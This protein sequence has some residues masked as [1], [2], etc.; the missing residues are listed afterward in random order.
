[1]CT[2]LTVFKRWKQGFL[3]CVHI[4]SGIRSPLWEIPGPDVCRRCP[5]SGARSPPASTTW[6]YYHVFYGDCTIKLDR[7]NINF[8]LSKQLN[9][10]VQSPSR[11]L[12]PFGRVALGQDEDELAGLV[13]VGV[14]QPSPELG[15]HCEGQALGLLAAGGHKDDTLPVDWITTRLKLKEKHVLVLPYCL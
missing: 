3:Q 8:L 6:W 11:K 1:M 13:V 9:F 4:L 7:F 10:S 12:I 5:E 15:E 2:Y 14:H